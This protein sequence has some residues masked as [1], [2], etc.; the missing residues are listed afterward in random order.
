MNC[1]NP[2]STETQLTPAFRELVG[3]GLYD[4]GVA[5]MGRH[6]TPDQIAEVLEILVDGGY[7]ADTVGGW[8]RPAEASCT[9]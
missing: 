3:A 1:V 9:L 8:I 4:W 2:G 5:Q 6:G 7:V